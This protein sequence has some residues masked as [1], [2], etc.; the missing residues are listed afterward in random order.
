MK[1][2]NGQKKDSKLSIQDI[3]S[4]AIMAALTAVMAQISI[5]MPLGVPMTMQTFAV[6]LAGVIL[7]SKRGALSMVV[8]LLIGSVGVPVFSN[9]GGGIQYL[10][11]PTGGFLLSFPIMA[12]LIG[13]GVEKKRQ[14]GMFSLYLILGTLVNYVVG[15]AM[16]CV[17]MDSTIW[18]GIS[19]CV[20]PF[21]PTAVVKAIAAAV[22][23][24]QV[25]KR[26]VAVLQ[27]A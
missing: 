21:I 14:K 24:L 4:V 19:A 20:I 3:C 22:L 7:G 16:Y 11:G 9:M 1:T 2:V 12:Y 13:V 8:Y 23:G 15:V 27:I 5:P 17:L 26:L 10:V 6:T 18:V 25:R